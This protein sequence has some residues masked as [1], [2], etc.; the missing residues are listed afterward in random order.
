MQI[1]FDFVSQ[2]SGKPTE[3]TIIN[4]WSRLCQFLAR[5]QACPS[6]SPS[7]H[8]VV[9]RPR[10]TLVQDLYIIQVN[11]FS[12]THRKLSST[13]VWSHIANLFSR[14]KDDDLAKS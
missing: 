4:P 11:G 7:P 8:K 12:E 10:V 9:L 3:L 1:T 6:I 2:I 5:G 14:E 13:I